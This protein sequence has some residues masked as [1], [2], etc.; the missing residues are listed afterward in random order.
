MKT[1]YLTLKIFALIILNDIGDTLAQALMKKG[2]IATGISSVGFA[3][4]VEFFIKGIHSPLLWL[5]ILFHVLNFFLWIVIL[6]KVD[7]SIAMP[8]G[9]FSYILIPMAA[10]IFLHEKVSPLRWLGIAF[11]VFGIY[12]VSKS[13]QKSAP[14]AAKDG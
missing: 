9:S 4:L 1:N 8:V 13:R 10:I 5:G 6:Y 14:E 7:L 12:F 11:I 3:N 2:V